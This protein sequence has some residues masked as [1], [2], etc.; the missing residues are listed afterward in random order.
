MARTRVFI[1]STFYDLKQVRADL[2]QFVRELGYEPVLNER[3][4]IPYGSEEALEQ[5]AY[6]EVEIADILVAIVGGRFGT[7]SSHAPYSISQIELKTAIE[8]GKQVYVFVDRSVMAEFSTYK[9]NKSLDGLKYQAV[10]DPKVYEFIEEIEALPRNN[11]IATFET[12]RD[13]TEYLREQWAGLFQRFLQEQVLRKEVRVLEDMKNTAKT[14]DQLVKF[15]TEERRN[16]DEAIQEILLSNHPIFKRLAEL[17]DTPYRVFF[18]NLDEFNT[19]IG[20]RGFHLV[21][22]AKWDHED[23]REW[24]KARSKELLKIAVNAFDDAGKLRVYTD[25][26]WKDDWV[27]VVTHPAPSAPSDDDD[28]PF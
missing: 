3:G 21:A 6:Q 14:L 24:Y 2:E 20:A 12:A 17:T 10:D 18:T 11:P 9:N 23:K 1:S 22:Q 26:E 25:A 5:Y 16:Q 19:W 8:T 13:I 15:L 4:S 7:S 27:D 28:I